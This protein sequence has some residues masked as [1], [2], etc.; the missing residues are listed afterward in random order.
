M[1]EAST[2]QL[3]SDNIQ[4][5]PEI[6]LMLLPPIQNQDKKEEVAVNIVENDGLDFQGK[7]HYSFYQM[8]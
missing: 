7:R 4:E 6:S 5:D 1:E 3:Y 2:I 8:S